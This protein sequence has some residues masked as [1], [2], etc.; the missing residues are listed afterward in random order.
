MER[1]NSGGSGPRILFDDILSAYASVSRR[2]RETCPDMVDG[3]SCVAVFKQPLIG[4]YLSRELIVTIVLLIRIWL[5]CY[6]K[7]TKISFIAMATYLSST[8]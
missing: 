7:N 6:C 8:G 4:V 2:S 3:G 1:R 5:S